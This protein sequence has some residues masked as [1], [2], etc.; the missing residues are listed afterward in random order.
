MQLKTGLKFSVFCLVIIGVESCSTQKDHFLNREYHS[1]NTKFNVLFNGEEALD[2]GSAI[3]ASQAQD[4][5]LTTLPVEL[6]TLDGEDENATASIPSFIRAE[7]KAV[8]AIQKHSMSFNGKQKNDQIHKAYLL[9]GKARYYDRRFLPALEAFNFLLGLNSDADVFYEGKLWR[10]K[11]NL[12]LG[13]DELAVSNLKPLANN[14]PKKN[15]LFAAVNATLAQ[16]FLNIQAIDSG[17]KYI[18]RAATFERKRIIQTRYRFIEAQ[19]FDQLNQ[20]DS[21]QLAF[22]SIVD[23]KRKAPRLYWMHAKL[24]ALRIQAERSGESPEKALEKL[25]AAFENENFTHLIY[26][27][28][29]QYHLSK[30]RDSLAKQFYNKSLKAPGIDRP[31]RRQN[32]RDLADDAFTRGHYVDTG[33][34]LDSL[35][36]Q[37]PQES[38]QKTIVSLEREGLQEVIGFEKTIRETDSILTLSAMIPEEQLAFYQKAI[39]TKRA[40]ELAKIE[41]EKKPLFNVLNRSNGKRFYFYNENLVVL[42]KQQFAS[43]FGNRPNAD[44]WNRLE[45]L[46]G[47][48]ASNEGEANNTNDNS[49]IVK[50]NAQAFVDLLPTDQTFLDSLS[51]LRNQAYL[52]VGVLYKEK[53]KNYDLASDRLKNVLVNSPKESQELNAW[54]HLYKM[55]VLRNPKLALVYEDKIIKQYPES[56][57]ARIIKDP[58]N[59]KLLPNETPSIRYEALYALFLEQQYEEVL[60]QGDDL[61]VIFSGT[62]MVSKVAHIMANATG[63]LDGIE[64]WKEQLQS[65]IE[66]YPN[67]E[68]AAQAKQTLAYIAAN[69]QE[70]E[71][72]RVYLNY[73]WI[74]PVLKENQEQIQQ[75]TSIV[76]QTLETGGIAHGNLSL[77]VYNRDYI[78]LIVNDLR[79][80]P[81]LDVKPQGETPKGLLTTISNKFVVLSSQYKD[82]QLFKSWNTVQ[83]NTDYEK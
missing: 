23:L 67:S 11:T 21:A 43:N 63:R 3:L 4:N 75:L 81:T 78:F 39:D 29:A 1:L 12:R 42:G 25:S 58:E 15:K 30:R 83:K 6:I 47:A 71:S 44:N 82:I 28:I 14:I 35:L 26:R 50:E 38:R 8:K 24:N 5:F 22:N 72:D 27:Q 64:V 66:I 79:Q 33:A 68:A 55:N 37:F 49:T 45:S 65:L 57:F 13:N 54:Y 41:L 80:Q 32:Y 73:K 2:I 34:Y 53:F 77:E 52:E 19:L 46:N 7:E 31:T 9:L 51:V 48:F 16:A 36:G 60:V 69:E 70:E 61:L 10:E 62:P 56:R 18:Q 76:T 20:K 59:F 74:F 40:K 17:L